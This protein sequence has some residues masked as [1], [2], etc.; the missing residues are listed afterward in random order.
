[1]AD[2]GPAINGKGRQQV[3]VLRDGVARKMELNIGAGDGKAVEILAGAAQGDQLI[4]SDTTP[5]KQHDSI[6]INH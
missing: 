2:S 1:V 6:R 5:F 3:Y 4:V